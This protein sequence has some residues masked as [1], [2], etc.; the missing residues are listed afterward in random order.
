MYT[1]DGRKRRKSKRKTKWKKNAANKG[2]ECVVPRSFAEMYTLPFPV[3]CPLFRRLLSL[4]VPCARRLL[5][6]L[7]IRESVL[8]RT[9]VHC[10]QARVIFPRRSAERVDRPSFCVYRN[11]QRLKANPRYA[12]PTQAHASVRI[13]GNVSATRRRVIGGYDGF[14]SRFSRKTTCTCPFQSLHI[15]RTVYEPDTPRR[16]VFPTK[17]V[18]DMNNMIYDSWR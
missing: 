12:E 11:K 18:C 7:T 3:Y 5:F 15:R 16:N 14:V 2:H 4:R 13:N 8:L 1:K 17:F 9:N 10:R 6:I